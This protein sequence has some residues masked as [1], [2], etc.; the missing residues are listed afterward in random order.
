MP[1]VSK[2]FERLIQKQI[3]EQIKNKLSPYLCG[4][5]KDFSTQYALLSFIE[6]WKKVLDEKGFGGA[7]SVDLSTAFDTLNYE[8]LMQKPSVYGSNNET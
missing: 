4:Y 2:F 7:V 5:R 1:P 3:N 8:M 6:C